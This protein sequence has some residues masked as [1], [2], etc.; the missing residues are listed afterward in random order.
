MV[1]LFKSTSLV[2]VV[3]KSKSRLSIV[4]AT[5]IPH[6][7]SLIRLGDLFA[8]VSP[9]ILGRL[10][11]AKSNE[12]FS[13]EATALNQLNGDKKILSSNENFLYFCSNSSLL[14]YSRYN[15]IENISRELKHTIDCNNDRF[16]QLDASS[17][18]ILKS[19]FIT[20]FRYLFVSSS[21]LNN[22]FGLIS[23]K[24]INYT[25]IHEP[26]LLSYQNNSVSL[27]ID[28]KVSILNLSSNV[29]ANGLIV[30]PSSSTSQIPTSTVNI[31]TPSATT[32]SSMNSTD[33]SIATT[34][35]ALVIGLFLMIALIV[36]L[37]F[38][39]RRERP[40]NLITAMPSESMQSSFTPD[41]PIKMVHQRQVTLTPAPKLINPIEPI[42]RN[43][44]EMKAEGLNPFHEDSDDSSI[45]HFQT[46]KI[47]PTRPV[48]PLRQLTES[49]YATE[50]ERNSLEYVDRVFI[51]PDAKIEPL[52]YNT[53]SQERQEIENENLC[54]ASQIDSST[55][56]D[57]GPASE[58]K[59]VSSSI[60]SSNFY[61]ASDGYDASVDDEEYSE[62]SSIETTKQDS[63]T[64]EITITLSKDV[65]ASAY[66]GL[67]SST[68]PSDQEYMTAS[69]SVNGVYNGAIRVNNRESIQYFGAVR[70]APPELEEFGE[71]TG[72]IVV[73]K[74][75]EAEYKGIIQ[76]DY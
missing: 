36:L 52:N 56:V 40:T 50:K 2:Y 39:K 30:E 65:E 12:T 72:P 45:A 38:C 6:S 24:S 48:T 58:D 10:D 68:S 1:F 63:E 47:Y 26:L 19:Q 28:G 31:L 43:S 73:R 53:L 22:S 17:F 76:I 66:A 18:V 61:S 9:T 37:R 16:I 71:Y 34:A 49:I 64:S 33:T 35:I 75:R 74:P 8:F 32:S 67:H 69:E 3:K 27:L 4:A 55:K 41:L 62:E 60:E 7:S 57:S 42:V 23:E 21:R 11:I 70:V 51:Q 29:S 46:V 20:L 44:V 54:A 15:L 59:R 5:R 25:K 13:I 14:S